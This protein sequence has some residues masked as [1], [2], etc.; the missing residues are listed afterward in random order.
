MSAR[1]WSRTSDLRLRRPTTPIGPF[2]TVS[3]PTGYTGISTGKPLFHVVLPSPVSHPVSPRGLPGSKGPLRRRPAAAFIGRPG[4]LHVVQ[5]ATG[6]W[7]WRID[8]LHEHWIGDAESV[9][10]ALD[11]ASESC[12]MAHFEARWREVRS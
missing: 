12:G 7:Q 5:V 6:L 1:C 2:V 4:V 8:G 9:A 3:Q 10:E 11:Q